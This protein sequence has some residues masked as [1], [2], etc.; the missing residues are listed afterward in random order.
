MRS[1]SLS[2]L[3]IL[4]VFL[5]CVSAALADEGRGR[6]HSVRF[7]IIGD[8]TGET[9][10]G[11]YEQIVTEIERLKPDFVITVGDM[12]EGYSHDTLPTPERWQEYLSIMEELSM[13]VYYTP[14][15]NDIVTDDRVDAY[16]EF[17]GF[18]PYH[19]FDFG[20]VHFVVL[21][22]SRWDSI[23][24]FPVEQWEWLADDLKI[25]REAPYTFVF[26][27]KP[28]WYRTIADNKPDTFHNLFKTYGVDAVFSGHFHRY[29]AGEFDGIKYTNVG[30]SGGS[31]TFQPWDPDYHFLWVTADTNGISIA[32]IEINSVLPWPKVRVSDVRYFE[33][34][35][36][37]GIT[38]VNAAEVSENSLEVKKTAISLDIRNLNSKM[39]IEDTARWTV[40]DGWTIEQL[41]MPVAIAPGKTERLTFEV[42]CAGN[43]YPLP[44]IEVGFPF[45]QERSFRVGRGIR[46]ARQAICTFVTEP[47]IIDGELNEAIWRN[48]AGE[49]LA[50]DGSPS[51]LDSTLFYF[52]H[53]TENLYVAVYCAEANTE[54]IRAFMT[55]H[56]DEVH[57]EDCV[58]FLYRP[59]GTEDAIYQLY[60]NPLG[61]TFDQKITQ[62]SDGYWTGNPSW[63]GNYETSAEIGKDGWS[64]EVRIPLGQFGATGEAGQKWDFNFRRKQYRLNAAGGW[65]VPHS[66]DPNDF[67][68]MVL[69]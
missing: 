21:D 37:L 59:K 47:P 58:G 42:S 13:P 61:T 1:A 23:E 18:D 57:R 46:I 27:H 60:V 3:S 51:K 11:I 14:G 25:H 35:R 43:L 38:F 56:D 49:L 65:Q 69:E 26:F 66:Y 10:P 68:Q 55:E 48:P 8:R 30:S 20:G 64:V 29:F 7:A 4:M 50:S 53:D 39:A 6:T 62:G 19:S 15:N 32:P 33:A 17:T 16:R 34:T 24:E 5:I 9:Q 63:D 54:S 31:A 2:R 41:S 28:F 36:W 67:G 22:N 40:P 45:D 12:I 44:Y 52:A